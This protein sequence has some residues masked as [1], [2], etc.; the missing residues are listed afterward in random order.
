VSCVRA[1]NCSSIKGEPSG[2]R[3]M[4]EA[5]LEQRMTALEDTVRELQEDWTI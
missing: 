1:P 3:Y 4:P 5:T 2:I